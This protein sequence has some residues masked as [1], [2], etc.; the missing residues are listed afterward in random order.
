[1]NLKGQKFNKLLVVCEK[2][3]K[4]R[5]IY[6]ECQCECGNIV[7]A[8]TGKLR[9]GHV[10]S[11]GCIKKAPKTKY[12]KAHAGWNGYGEISG[13]IWNRIKQSAKQRSKEFT[14]KIEE[15]WEIYENQGGKCALTDL[16]LVFAQTSKDLRNR[17]NTCSL[18]RI[19]SSKGYI[20]G[21]VQW[22]HVKINYMKQNFS[23]QEFI[24][25]C[26]KVWIK[27]GR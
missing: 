11:C 14:I 5:Q 15:A 17:L 21:N 6:W 1:V 26:G 25:F 24:D 22:V 19:D 18:D 13:S 10:K 9:Y 23:Q 12:G 8:C 2:F 20:L 27:N 3:R 16:P 4:N 7:T